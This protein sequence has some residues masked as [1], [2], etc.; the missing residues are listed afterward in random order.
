VEVT[1]TIPVSRTCEVI[2][3]EKRTEQK[4]GNKEDLR[5]PLGRRPL[6]ILLFRRVKPSAITI[7]FSPVFRI[8]R[9]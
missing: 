7:F 6:I 5:D 9:A 1:G 4:K 2:M 3:K 8:G